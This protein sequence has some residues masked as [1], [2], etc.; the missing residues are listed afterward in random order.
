MIVRVDT[1]NLTRGAEFSVIVH[2]GPVPVATL[3]AFNTA[4]HTTEELPHTIIK[5]GVFHKVVSKAPSFDGFLLAKINSK[6]MVVKKIGHPR[7]HFV[8]AHKE[9]Y[10]IS[11]KLFNEEGSEVKRDTLTNI[12]DGFYYCE[13]PD[14]TTIMETLRKRF[15]LKNNDTKFNFEV[16]M[17]DTTLD[18][19]VLP[20][21]ELLTTL[22]DSFLPEVILEAVLI[23][24]TLPSVNIKE[25]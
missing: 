6:S 7:P 22:G 2:G 16:E 25:F 8:I 18:D 4:S 19:V 15:I 23:N 9:G 12:I 13:I 21:Y 24:A 3:Y 1:T 17:S 5:D 10:N 20:E 11:Y 14:N